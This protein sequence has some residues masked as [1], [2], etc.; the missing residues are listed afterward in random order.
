MLFLL[1][2]RCLLAIFLA[3]ACLRATDD[4]SLVW[5]STPPYAPPLCLLFDGA[6]VCFAAADAMP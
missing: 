5:H 3:R 6:F 4:I 2:L 1:M